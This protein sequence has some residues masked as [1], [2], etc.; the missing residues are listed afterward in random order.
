MKAAGLTHP[1]QRRKQNQDSFSINPE[2]KLFIVAD[3]MGGHYGG[4]IASKTAIKEIED[5]WKED[6]TSEK[7]PEYNIAEAIKRANREIHSFRKNMGT[8]LELFTIIDK[9]GWIGHVGDSRIYRYRDGKLEM[10]TNDHTRVR[11]LIESGELTPEVARIYPF[12]HIIT[13]AVGI[14]EEI[15][16]D[17]A[18]VELKAGDMIIM[19]SDGL[20]GDLAKKIVSEEDIIDVLSSEED[21]E[22]SCQEMVDIANEE[23]GPDNITVVIVQIEEEDIDEPGQD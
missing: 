1:G 4:E 15:L 14:E 13:R 19:C 21:L 2:E 6:Y 3:G 10:L 9:K 20:T 18:P 7:S 17:T 22:T 11:E 23:G 8:T 5:Y 16:I 12:Q